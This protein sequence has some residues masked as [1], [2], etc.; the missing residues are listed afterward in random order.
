MRFLPFLKPNGD[1]NVTI[2]PDML[3]LSAKGYPIWADA[4]HPTV[5]KVMQ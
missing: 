4:I 2:Q 3:H 1:G 5:R